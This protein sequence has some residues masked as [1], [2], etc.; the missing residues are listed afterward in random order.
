LKLR[1]EKGEKRR[2]YFL[3]FFICVLLEIKR[4]GSFG[5]NIPLRDLTAQSRSVEEGLAALSA[6][7]ARRA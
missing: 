1:E 5:A 3:F 7:R 4:R 6:T 2:F